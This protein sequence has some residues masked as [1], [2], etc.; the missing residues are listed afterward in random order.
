MRYNCL[1]YR[2]F[3]L[4]F[5]LLLLPQS[6]S[7]PSQP[8]PPPKK[9]TLA[10]T[11]YKTEHVILFV[12]DGVR[13]S[14]SWGDAKRKNIPKMA[15]ELAPQGSLYKNFRNEGMTFTVAGHT[16]LATGFYIDINNDGLEPPPKP[17]FLQIWREAAAKSKEKAWIVSGKV[18]L[19]VLAQSLHPDWKE[20][21][22]PS[23]DYG[24]LYKNNERI[25]L[26]RDDKETFQKLLEILKKH[27]PSVVL[28]AFGEPDYAGHSNNWEWYIE[29]IR[30]NDANVATLWKFLQN[31]PFYKGKTTLLITHDHGRHLDG[32]A[33]G[34]PSH[35]DDCEGCRRLSLL[36][37][38]PDVRKGHVIEKKAEQIDI[39][40]TIGH[41]LG[42]TI[43]GAKGRILK[44][45]LK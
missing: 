30:E 33:D 9:P 22:Y 5:L 28:A 29:S 8:P 37:L 31:D 44:E 11:P 3:V 24:Y 45:M 27:R 21:A 39:P 34:F 7:K 2:Y 38:G 13:Y 43:P 10:Q 23:V 41:L 12:I 18:K 16:A 32:H 6:C 40:P 14:E 19:K 36:A 17:S 25:R 15:K 20:K 4:V 42:F 35:G 26:N 1:L